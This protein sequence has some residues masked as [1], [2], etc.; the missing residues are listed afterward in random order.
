MYTS[1]VRLTDRNVAKLLVLKKA[2][3]KERCQLV[4]E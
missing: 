3:V 2:I 4:L 1:T